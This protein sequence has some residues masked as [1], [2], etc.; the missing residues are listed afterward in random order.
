MAAPSGPEDAELGIIMHY[1]SKERHIG[2]FWDYE[3]PTIQ[4]LTAKG[5]SSEFVYGFDW[6]WRA[7]ES[8]RRP[9]RSSC[10]DSAWP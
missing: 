2:S 3:S 10:L 7:E 4:A 5:L 6:H 1:Q 9:G 8:A